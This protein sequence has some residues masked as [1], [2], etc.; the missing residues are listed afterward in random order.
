MTDTPTL[1]DGDLHVR[2]DGPRDAPVLLL[3]HGSA[4]S[5]RSWD[6]LVPHLTG[7]H[8]IVRPDLLGHG[9]SA[10]PADRSYALPDQARRL[11]AVLDRLG[12]GHA[13]AV[14]HSSGGAV[15]TA[16]AEQRPDLVTGLALINTGPGLYAYIASGAD[17]SQWPPTDE[18]IRRFASTGFSRPGYEIPAELLDEVRHMTL[19]TLTATMQATRAYL[20]ERPLPDRLAPLGKPLLVLFGEDDRR[21][22]SS[23]AADYGTVPGARIELLP[24]LGHSP[25]L[26]DPQRTAASLLAFTTALSR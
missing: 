4:S 15:A 14:G 26:E 6:A 20:D 24:G 17:I 11:G 9:R 21:W 13:V 2:Q 18:E 19:H 7:S 25:I 1:D 3:I 22:R 5:A 12:V 16:L 23:S 8:H 10:K